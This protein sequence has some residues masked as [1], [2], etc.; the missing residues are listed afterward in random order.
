MPFSLGGFHT[1]RTVP[2]GSIAIEQVPRPKVLSIVITAIVFLSLSWTT[3]ALRIWTRAIVVHSFGWDDATM[4]I[5]MVGSSSSPFKISNTNISQV[6]FTVF[7]TGIMVTAYVTVGD[8]F[9][10]IGDLTPAINV[11]LFNFLYLSRIYFG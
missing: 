9:L 6:F 2:V 8:S 3:V 11:C 10:R 7:C 5:S 4:V 1:N